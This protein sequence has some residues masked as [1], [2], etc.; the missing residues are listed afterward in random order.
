MWSLN[1]CWQVKASFSPEHGVVATVVGKA[2]PR[3]MHGV[4]GVSLGSKGGWGV[5][6]VGENDAETT[7]SVDKTSDDDDGGQTTI[8][9]WR[10]VDE[11][12]RD[13]SRGRGGGWRTFAHEDRPVLSSRDAP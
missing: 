4:L 2:W 10:D 6:I 11:G 5:S 1:R 12:R 8:S 9:T 13:P 7:W 3:V